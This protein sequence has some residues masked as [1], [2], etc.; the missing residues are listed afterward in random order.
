[1]PGVG[2]SQYSSGGA[3]K[4]SCTLASLIPPSG[5]LSWVVP[6]PDVGSFT[7]GISHEE[8]AFPPLYQAGKTPARI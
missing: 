7:K 4:G 2:S 1:M 8:M 6:P 3:N 5:L